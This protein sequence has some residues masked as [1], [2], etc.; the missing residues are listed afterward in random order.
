MS[1]E[2]P[3]PNYEPS[4]ADF[5]VEDLT[6]AQSS[7]GAASDEPQIVDAQKPI[8]LWIEENKWL[9][10]MGAVLATIAI[11]AFFLIRQVKADKFLAASQEFTV[12]KTQE[13]YQK[14]IE[15]YG[16]TVQAGNA[17]LRRAQLMY[18]EGSSDEAFALVRKFVEQ[19]KGHPLHAQGLVALGT[20][21]ASEGRSEAALSNFREAIAL[22][23]KAS[24]TAFARIREGDVLIEEGEYEEARVVFENIPREHPGLGDR[25]GDILDERRSI[26]EQ[27]KKEGLAKPLPPLDPDRVKPVV[28]NP[29]LSPFPVGAPGAPNGLEGLQNLPRQG[30]PAAPAP[31][32]VTPPVSLPVP[33]DGTPA[34][35]LPAQPDIPAAPQLELDGPP[36]RLDGAEIPAAPVGE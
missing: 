16:G 22:Y 32:V 31:S 8:E 28:V 18:D 21:E 24:I 25:F 23:P 3:D 17:Y 20:M 35:A 36:V 12:A 19:Y 26:V 4:A 14:I 27:L 6:P 15:D 30:A 7:G 11:S 5:D 1:R 2:K 9:I 13:D 29:G 33:A 10:M 34:P